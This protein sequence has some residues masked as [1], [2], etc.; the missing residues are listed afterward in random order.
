MTQLQ[1]VYITAHGSYTSGAWVGESAQFGLRLAMADSTSMPAMGTTFVP[2]AN[3]DVQTD[4]GQTSGAHGTLTRTWT[5]RLGGTGSS[6]NADA[7]FQVDM[8]EDMW[9]F[10]DTLKSY[11]HSSFRWSGVKIAPVS[12]AGATIGT[13][14]VYNFTSAIPGSSTNLLPPQLA[15]AI[16]LRANILGRRGRGRIYIP[17]L[18]NSDLASDGTLSTAFTT[19][20]RAAMV[21]LIGNLQD[22]PGA[23]VVN[24][25]VVITSAGMA[26]VVRP[27]EVRTGQRADTIRSRRAQVPETYTTTALS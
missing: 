9:T 22:A 17:A 27:S 19:A 20:I 18:V 26:S 10:L 7:A 21:T 11:Q 13:S 15:A 6:E 16:T 2:M 23:N 8:A 14:S 24:P 3:G 4:Q 1:H 5:A 12:A 25:L